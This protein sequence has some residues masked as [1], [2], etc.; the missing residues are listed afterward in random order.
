MIWACGVARRTGRLADVDELGPRRGRREHP[1]VDEPVVHDHIGTSQQRGGSQ[2][3]QIRIARSGADEVHGHDA[4]RF[5][6]SD[7]AHAVAG[8]LDRPAATRSNSSSSIASSQLG[9]LGRAELL[10]SLVAHLAEH[11]E[12]AGVH[13]GEALFELAPHP[14]RERRAAAVGRDG[15]LQVAAGDDGRQDE[16]AVGRI[17]RRVDEDVGGLAVASHLGVDLRVVGGGDRQPVR[18]NLAAAVL[19][20]VPAHVGILGDLGD[21]VGRDHG[22]AA[23]ARSRPA[24]FRAATGPPPTTSTRRPRR[25]RLTGYVTGK[26]AALTGADR[27]RSCPSRPND[28]I[29]RVDGSVHGQQPI[30]A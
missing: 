16:R 4:T 20:L 9:Y 6:P 29:G 7:A 13:V 22:D 26:T 30:D 25:S 27:T 10:A 11:V 28:P 23:P 17:V 15:E 14:L 19:A 5:R 8:V 2:G 21:R 24:T 1:L 3:Q 18:S 12:H